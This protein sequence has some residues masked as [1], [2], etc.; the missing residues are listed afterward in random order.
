M[1][2]HQLSAHRQKNRKKHTMKGVI[3]CTHEAE[4]HD[5]E[6]PEGEREV[7]DDDEHEAEDEAVEA[8]LPPAVDADAQAS[9]ASAVARGATGLLLRLLLLLARLM[10][11]HAT[12]VAAG[13]VGPARLGSR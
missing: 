10:P 6:E 1:F 8:A 12:R 4:L 2:P 3:H 13:L 7:E 5:P 9:R 11:S